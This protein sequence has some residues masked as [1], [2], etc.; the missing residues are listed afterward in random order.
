MQPR[1]GEESE[2]EEFESDIEDPTPGQQN[3]LKTAKHIPADP[4]ETYIAK[5]KNTTPFMKFIAHYQDQKQFI[6][7]FKQFTSDEGIKINSIRK[8]TGKEQTQSIQFKNKNGTVV[9]TNEIT[10]KF[11]L[12][13]PY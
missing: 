6:A 13:F 7:N 5:S 11:A 12:K 10:D 3:A 2:D 8:K 1:T 9:K 4:L